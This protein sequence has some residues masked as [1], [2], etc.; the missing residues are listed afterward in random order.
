MCTR[1]EAGAAGFNPQKLTLSSLQQG[2]RAKAADEDLGET[3]WGSHM[4]APLFSAQ[5]Q[6]R[7]TG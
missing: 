5:L 7:G 2:P 3:S 6:G 4:W 1:P